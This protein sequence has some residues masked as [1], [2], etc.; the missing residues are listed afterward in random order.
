MYSEAAKPLVF[1]DYGPKYNDLPME[2]LVKIFGYLTAADRLA[3]GTT[4]KRWLEA[5]Q[6][7]QFVNDICLNFY[8]THFSDSCSPVC[9]LLASTRTFQNIVFSQVEFHE[10]EQFFTCFGE[11]ILELTFKAC[12]IRE[13]TFN[14]IL[15]LVPNLRALRVEGCRELL[16]S[17]R[18]FDSVKQDDLAQALQNLT[19]LSLAYNRYLS[20]A[21]FKRIVSLTPNLV[22][23]DLSGCPISF[24]KGLYRKF[25][26]IQL[27]DASES[28]LTFH[29]ISQFLER[30]ADKLKTVNFSLT[31]IDGDSLEM[32]AGFKNLR[33]DTLDLNS[34]DQ[35]TNSGITA[36]AQQQTSLQHLDFS[37]SVRFTDSCLHKICL[38]LTNL[39]SLNLRR[40][41]ALTDLGIKELVN[42]P[43][44][45]ALDISEC[46]SIT[47]QGIINGIASKP[48]S[49]LLEL[50]V[51]ALNLC[52]SSVIKIAETFPSLRVLD[53][54]YCFHSISDLCLQMI[55]KNLI[56][57]RHLN[58]DYCDKIS[59]SAMT[60]VGMLSKVR[61]Y[62]ENGMTLPKLASASY[63]N[64]DEIEP[65]PSGSSR[66]F[67]A[68]SPEEPFK[69]SIR[70]KAEQEIVNDAMRKR[71]MMEIC[72]QNQLVKDEVGSGFSINRLKGLRVLR[73]SQCNK[74]SDISLMYAF[75]LNELKEISLAKCQQIS[76]VGIRSLVQNCPSLE[77]VDLSECH[78]INDKAI[79]LIAVHLRRL[80]TLSLDR[81][82]Q[83]SDFSLDYIAIH[84]KTLRT[85]DVRGCRN[86]C[87]EPSL[88]LVN[89][90]TLRT[91]HMS[92][93]GPYMGEPG[94]FVK[95]P[96][97]PPMPKRI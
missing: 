34:C 6:Y 51:S 17:G 66:V 10:T 26:P 45:Q 69:I 36:L 27:D 95:K 30:Q 20:D 38:N 81:C 94:Y 83:L 33:L 75:K 60:G 70:S 96:P 31:L 35:L 55:F 53:L 21:L 40:C 76:I 65:V 19:T 5:T 88:R 86:M 58:L 47:G 50:Y 73:L 93:P 84:C 52:E 44:L 57:L 3:A 12:D 14:S 87:A 43:K 54:S 77:V 41:R 37:K 48:S 82:F 80:Q 46:E 90:P 78:N 23:L 22:N 89:I 63:Q 91:V 67:G 85:L 24:H 32:L 8:K 7:Q 74:L 79:E 25:Y 29:Y 18:L 97:P 1:D 9:N 71:A 2:I 56:W 61:D 13:R 28:V 72:Q 4:C 16:M 49:I 64:A 11:N 59:D 68:G 15:M 39:K 92:K 62:E 42:L